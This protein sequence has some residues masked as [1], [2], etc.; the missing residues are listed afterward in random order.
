[1]TKAKP[2]QPAHMTE[3]LPLRLR[4]L[5]IGESEAVVERMDIT[6]IDFRS[7]INGAM[8]RR[9]NLMVK[10]AARAESVTGY[11]FRINC[12]YFHTADHDLMICAV[13][14]RMT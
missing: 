2:S 8:N 4:K 1:M 5:G 10:A 9:R 7:D 12:S 13:A 14:T 11:G 3:S 6:A